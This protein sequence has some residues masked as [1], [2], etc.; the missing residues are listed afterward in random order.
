ME[1][2]YPTEN[3]KV[4]NLTLM[5]EMRKENRVP[6]HICAGWKEKGRMRSENTACVC[7]CVCC[8]RVCVFVSWGGG[9]IC[10]SAFVCASSCGGGRLFVRFVYNIDWQRASQSWKTQR[11]TFAFVCVS[12]VHKAAAAEK[13]KVDN[14]TKNPIV[15][16]EVFKL[17]L[18]P[19]VAFYSVLC[20]PRPLHTNLKLHQHTPFL[21]LP[22]SLS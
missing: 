10:V 1:R 5:K 18:M 9:G 8:L 6:Q 7:V 19:F 12:P 15:G 13:K 11:R 21:L 14:K 4:W 17:I 3:N 20:S 22:P 16:F 2:S